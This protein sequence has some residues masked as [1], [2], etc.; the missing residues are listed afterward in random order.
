MRKAQ[1][2]RRPDRLPEPQSRQFGVGYR[3]FVEM[4]AGVVVGAGLGWLLDEWF[5]TRPWLLLVMIL[6]GFAAGMSNAYRVTR[7]IAAEAERAARSGDGA[8]S[9]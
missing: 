7:R 1:E 8:G 6:L 5:G 4:L 2:A 3:V 9:G